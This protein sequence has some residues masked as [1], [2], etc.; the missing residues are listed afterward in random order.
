MKVTTIEGNAYRLLVKKIERVTA[1]M[2]E[3]QNREET[4]HERKEETEDP[5]TKGRKAGPKWMMHR[6][7]CEAL[8]ISHHTP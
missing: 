3:S 5:V 7:A 6:E 8:D 1:Y 2:E 4:E